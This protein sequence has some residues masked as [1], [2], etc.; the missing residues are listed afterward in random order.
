MLIIL[1]EKEEIEKFE[2]VVF[3]DRRNGISKLSPRDGGL[4]FS[5]FNAELIYA[6]FVRQAIVILA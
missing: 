3:T 2:G 4:L 5:I 1:Y 6:G